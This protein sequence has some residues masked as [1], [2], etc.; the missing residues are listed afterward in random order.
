M[1]DKKISIIFPC[2]NEEL[3]IGA[4]ITD[5]IKH[6]ESND[7]SYEI[8]VS[9]NGS[10]DNSVTLAKNLGASVIHCHTRGYGAAIRAGIAAAQGDYIFMLDSDASY[11][12]EN[13]SEFIEKLNAGADLVMGDR[14]GGTIDA[15]A[16]PGL[17]KYLGNPVLSLIGRLLFKVRIR[18]F[19]CGLRAFKRLSLER[20]TLISDGMEFASELVAQFALNNLKI[21]QVPVRLRKDQRNRPPHLRSWADGWRHLRYLIINSKRNIFL[22]TGLLLTSISA[23][24]SLLLILEGGLQVGRI[25]LS[26]QSLLILNIVFLIGTQSIFIHWILRVQSAAYFEYEPGVDSKVNLASRLFNSRIAEKIGLVGLGIL[27]IGLIGFIKS[28]RNWQESDFGQLEIEQALRLSIPSGTF[29][30]LGSQIVFMAI[31]GAAISSIQ[32]SNGKIL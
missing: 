32:K 10:S 22:Q 26:S 20:V 9:D 5:A 15:G 8:I 28:I 4:C 25:V 23:I 7:L 24:T 1:T 13:I 30:L 2:L 16:M 6:L 3:T 12:L 11:S 29:I 21:D 31:S 18:D 14:F 27:L 17:H 19:H